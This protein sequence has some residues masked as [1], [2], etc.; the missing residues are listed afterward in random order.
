MSEKIP[1]PIV[2]AISWKI[3]SAGVVFVPSAEARDI[4]RKAHRWRALFFRMRKR[5][6]TG[7]FGKIAANAIKKR[8][9]AER[10]CDKLREQNERLNAQLSACAIAAT[11]WATAHDAETSFY[12]R[13]P[14]Y[15]D[16]MRLRAERD[17]LRDENNKMR[18]KL[19]KLEKE[20]A[21]L[22]G[23]L[24]RAHDDNWKHVE[25]QQQDME[26]FAGIRKDLDL[27]QKTVKDLRDFYQDSY[28]PISIDG[29]WKTLAE[30]DAHFGI[31]PR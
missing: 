1:T 6:Q 3:T 26:D 24:K 12:A 31:A 25:R 16:V 23:L 30:Y 27:A 21:R 9:V 14:A 5:A 15:E 2:D 8:Y 18:E 7:L 22:N 13:S 17:K 20:V 10:G 11:G 4:E 28:A 29:V 19:G